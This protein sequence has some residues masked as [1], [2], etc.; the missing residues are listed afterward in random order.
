MVRGEPVLHVMVSLSNHDN[1][2]K[3]NTNGSA[4]SP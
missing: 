2:K 1:V 4:G 3:E